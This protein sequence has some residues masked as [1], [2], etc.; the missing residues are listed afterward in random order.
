MPVL[1]F[2]TDNEQSLLQL[3]E[4]AAKS[5]AQYIL[6][7]IGMTLREG[8]REYFYTEL[9]TKFPGLR[10]LYQTKYGNTYSCS[11]PEGTR[12]WK[13]LQNRCRELNL[14][15]QMKFYQPENIV[16]GKLFI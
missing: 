13:T 9:D 16:Q 7:W 6:I 4:K 1:P 10:E 15:T 11:I 8:Q 3:V 12:V 2:I 5:G 14:P